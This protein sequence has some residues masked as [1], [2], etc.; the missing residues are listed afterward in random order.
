MDNYSVL[1]GKKLAGGGGGGSATLIDKDITANG[2]YNA[3]S[4]NADG[5]RKVVVGV[6]NTY[7]LADEGKVVDSGALEAQTSKSINANGTYDTT[8][9]NE[10]VVAVPNSYTQSDE[11]K[12]VSQGTLVTQTTYP[13]TVTQNGTIDTTL[14]DSVEISV[15]DT[16]TK[17]LIER[18]GSS[19]VVP[20]G[21][22]TLGRYSFYAWSIADITLPQSLMTIRDYALAQSGI[23]NLVIPKNVVSIGVMACGNNPNLVSITFEA[24]SSLTTI[25]TQMCWACNKLSLITIPSSVISIGNNAF[26]YCTNLS[27]ITINK[28]EGSISGAPWGAPNATVVW[29]G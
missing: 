3:R 24:P 23:A 15:V 16:L 27:T 17:Q 21:I 8:L 18:T 4:D 1:F 26:Q 29:T 13:S 10:V 5:F 28:A 6:P 12:V 20:E 7:T 25:G 14:Y 22:T 2:T 9:N 11:G 19:V